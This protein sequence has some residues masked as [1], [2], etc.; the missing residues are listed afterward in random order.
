MQLVTKN[1]ESFRAL[2]AR[3]ALTVL[4]GGFS[5]LEA[6]MAERAGFEAFFLAGSQAAAYLYAVPDAG[7]LG[8][9]D[10]AGQAGHVAARAGIPVLVDGD[11]GYGNAVN[12]YF[13]VQ[14][15]VRSGAAAVQIE[16]QV[17]PKKSGTSAAGAVSRSR[18]RWAST[19]PRSVHGMSST[20]SSASARA[21]TPSGPRAVGSRR[22]SSGAFAT[23]RTAAL[24]SCG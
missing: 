19:G 16:D 24:T 22:Q 12:V 21:V 1:R 15:L 9:H 23:L 17:A 20:R 10:M 13:A 18:R 6:V 2:L 5:P 4:P 7:I 8:L 14:A 3:D 11:T